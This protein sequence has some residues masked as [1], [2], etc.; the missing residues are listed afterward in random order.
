MERNP[1]ARAVLRRR[2]RPGLIA[3]AVGL[4]WAPAGAA[5]DLWAPGPNS[6]QGH[7]TG[8]S[9]ELPSGQVLLAGGGANQ[10]VSLDGELLSADGTSFG[11]AGTMRQGRAYAAATLLTDGDVLIAGGDPSVTQ[12]SALAT[13]QLWKPAGGGTFTSTG[14]MHVARQVFTLTTLPNGFAMAV[15]GSPAVD[16][17][18]GSP[19]AELYN[20]SAGTWTPTGP[21]PSGR[22]GHTATLLANCKVLIVGDAPEALT[23]NYATGKFSPAGREG[24]FQRSYHTA[25]LLSSGKVLIAGG[26]TASQQALN[27][28]SVY[29]PATGKFT[30]TANRMATFHSQGFAAR[31]LDGRVI[32]GG[33]FSDPVHGTV[34]NQV[35]IYDPSTDRWSAGAPLLP[36]SLAFSVEAQTLENGDVALMSTGGDNGS[37][38]YTPSSAGPSVSPPVENC[39]DLF[40]IV[41]TT[42]GR[43]GAI[44]VRLALP[45]AGTVKASAVVPAQSGVT[46]AFSYGV[47][48]GTAGH[49]GPLT[50]T[51]SPSQAAR[52]A[53]RSEGKLRVNL[54]VAFTPPQASAVKRKSSVI[55]R[56]S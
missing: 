43:R 33:G 4:L 17:G 45:G 27:T 20:P 53:L 29:D 50:V 39:S 51:V 9:V 52:T 48:T 24:S 15:G 8:V 32:V 36:G 35:E 49:W 14:P 22:L 13:A 10:S 1:R 55:A 3:V 16:S 26:E 34:S 28:A 44:T 54:V 47:A 23:Y 12:G 42:S 56:W 2:S 31:L 18:A 30:P 40:S 5:A 37:E 7:V 11:L 19:T 38:I 6:S 21:M 25:T 41:S 46:R